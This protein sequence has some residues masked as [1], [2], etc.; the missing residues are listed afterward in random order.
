MTSIPTKCRYCVKH[1]PH[2]SFVILVYDHPATWLTTT[3]PLALNAE[4]SPA[5]LIVGPFKSEKNGPSSEDKANIFTHV[6]R[7]C[8]RTFPSKAAR[9]MALSKFWHMYDKGQK[10]KELTVTLGN[11]FHKKSLT[12]LFKR[13][14]S[15]VQHIQKM[16]KELETL[17]SPSLNHSFS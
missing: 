15:S 8:N 7:K 11:K 5:S 14:A 12:D 17:A 9:G 4:H 13:R 16:I 10:G 2:P 6:V 3:Q 1:K